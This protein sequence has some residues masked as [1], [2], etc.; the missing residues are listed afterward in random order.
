MNY[1]P[2]ILYVLAWIVTLV[3][4][5]HDSDFN[6]ALF[7]NILLFNI[8]LQGIWAWLGHC[9]HSEKV[10]ASIGWTTSPFQH[11]VGYVCLAIGVT[12]ITGYFLPAFSYGA[13]LVAS[14]FLG[15]AAFGHIRDII[16]NKNFAPG[17]AGP[18]LWMDILIPIHVLVYF[19]FKN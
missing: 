4:R 16:K 6:Q 3:F 1:F 7:S 14:I 18:M 10:A 12:G 19:L 15:S 17:N 8:G 13:A 9:F 11:E 2:V 5:T